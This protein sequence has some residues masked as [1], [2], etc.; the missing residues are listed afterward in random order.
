M[1]EISL[2]MT[3]KQILTNFPETLEVFVNSGF[4]QF[5][6]AEIVKQFGSFLQLGTALK[7]KQVDPVFFLRLLEESIEKEK[8]GTRDTVDLDTYYE[9]SN[10]LHFLAMLPCPVKVPLEKQLSTFIKAFKEGGKGSLTHCLVSNANN[11]LSFFDYVRCYEHIDELPDVV[12]ASGF[13]GF[14]HKSFMQ[15]FKHQG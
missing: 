4:S 10:S 1:T 6:N 9:E 5:G 7:T 3:I 14:Y 13:N 11:H 2:K 8:S 15:R 12:I